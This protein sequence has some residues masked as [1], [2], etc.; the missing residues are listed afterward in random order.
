M[1]STCSLAEKCSATYC[2]DFSGLYLQLIKLIWS[3]SD[4]L[5]WTNAQTHTH[6]SSFVMILLSVFWIT[7]FVCLFGKITWLLQSGMDQLLT[8]DFTHYWL[9]C[10]LKSHI[11]FSSI[12]TLAMLLTYWLTVSHCWR[13][14]LDKCLY[15][16]CCCCCCCCCLIIGCW[17]SVNW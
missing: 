4:M 7:T 10:H 8:Q 9:K 13:C 5:V 1:F 12:H 16:C 3:S 14:A 17:L 6:T 2:G 11:I 15:Y